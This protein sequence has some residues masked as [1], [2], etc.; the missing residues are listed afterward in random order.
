MALETR[1]GVVIRSITGQEHD[2]QCPDAFCDVDGLMGREVVGGYVVEKFTE[3]GGEDLRLA[4]TA[5]RS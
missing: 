1:F 5:K 3:A 2:A 4:Q